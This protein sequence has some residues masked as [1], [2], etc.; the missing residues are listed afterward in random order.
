[1][2]CSRRVGGGLSTC[3]HRD[4]VPHEDRRRRGGCRRGWSSSGPLKNRRASPSTRCWQGCSPSLGAVD[5][6]SVTQVR[7][8]SAVVLRRVGRCAIFLVILVLRGDYIAAMI[9]WTTTWSSVARGLPPLRSTRRDGRAPSSSQLSSSSPR[10]FAAG[11]E[12]VGQLAGRGGCRVAAWRSGRD[13][14]RLAPHLFGSGATARSAAGAP[15]RS[16]RPAPPRR[17]NYTNTPRAIRA[18]PK[19]AWA[20]VAGYEHTC[21]ILTDHSLTCW[22]DAT[23]GKLGTGFTS[24]AYGPLAVTLPGSAHVQQVALGTNHTCASARTTARSPAGGATSSANSATTTRP[25][26]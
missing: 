10:S 16:P 6:R 9:G 1:M 17:S 4:V 14:S 2:S 12:R 3:G 19:Q 21:A 13:R 7:L 23:H 8:S 22:G 18:P 11:P 26:T 5:R 20:V 24:G 15:T 25:A